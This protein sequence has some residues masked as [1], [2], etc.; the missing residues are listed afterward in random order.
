M[1]W[2]FLRSSHK[3]S[4]H[5]LPRA[6]QHRV[7]L[8]TSR[9]GRLAGENLGAYKPQENAWPIFAA[10]ATFAAGQIGAS[11]SLKDELK[12]VYPL[13]F[14][15]CCSIC[16]VVIAIRLALDIPTAEFWL[17]DLS[18]FAVLWTS[19]RGRTNTG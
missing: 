18:G 2:P 7:G 12:L 8:R 14:A 10:G 13:L 15:A 1:V 9:L 3:V 16:T 6:G 19:L 11:A 17:R 5:L 4:E